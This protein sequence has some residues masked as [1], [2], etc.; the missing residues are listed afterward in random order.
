MQGTKLELAKKLL[1]LLL[2][3]KAEAQQVSAPNPPVLGSQEHLDDAVDNSSVED[4]E[5]ASTGFDE[6][7]NDQM[8]SEGDETEEEEE[9]EQYEEEEMGE[10]LPLAFIV[11]NLEEDKESDSD[12]EDE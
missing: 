11:P 10:I 5:D 9:V 4:D 3:E 2:E 12:D 8:D 1:T 6:D 7:A